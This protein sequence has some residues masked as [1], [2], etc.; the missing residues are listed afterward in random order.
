[1]SIKIKSINHVIG[2]FTVFLSFLMLYSS[3]VQKKIVGQAKFEA[4]QDDLFA[5]ESLKTLIKNNK[6]TK[7]VVRNLVGNNNAIKVSGGDPGNSLINILEKVFT[8][9]EFIVRDRALFEK[10]F[11]QSGATDYSKMKDLT[12]TDLILELVQ[13]SNI[14]YVTNTYYK[15]GRLKK[16]SSLQ[17]PLQ[18]TGIKIELKIIKVKEN[19]IVGTYTFYDSPCKDGCDVYKYLKQYYAY[20]PTNYAEAYAFSYDETKWEVFTENV[21]KKL[22]SSIKD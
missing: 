12:D 13:I 11:N 10:S 7:I 15:N 2:I 17:A 20:D 8:K 9:N 22:I 14:P 19:D 16:I 4:K 1:M 5:K 3:G 6:N 18:Y 21:A